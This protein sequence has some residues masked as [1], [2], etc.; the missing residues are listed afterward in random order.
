MSLLYFFNIIFWNIQGIAFRDLKKHKLLY[1]MICS[2][3][4]QSAVRLIYTMSFPATLLYDCMKTLNISD[5]NK[6]KKVPGLKK[7]HERGFWILELASSNQNTFNL[8]VIYKQLVLIEKMFSEKKF[9]DSDDEEECYGNN[10]L[11]RSRQSMFPKSSKSKCE[12]YCIKTT[13]NQLFSVSEIQ[14]IFTYIHI[15][16]SLWCNTTR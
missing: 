10:T 15:T 9:M 3:A 13:L 14:Y 1:P 2:T 16:T 11:K 5:V 7:I 4:S 8:Y 12:S 6:L